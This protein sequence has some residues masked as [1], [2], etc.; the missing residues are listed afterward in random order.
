MKTARSDTLRLDSAFL[1]QDIYSLVVFMVER[2][3]SHL[4]PYVIGAGNALVPLH[5]N[6]PEYIGNA[7]ILDCTR[8][9]TLSV[10]RLVPHT[11]NQPPSFV[12][13]NSNEPFKPVHL[14]HNMLEIIGGRIVPAYQTYVDLF[15]NKEKE[16][17]VKAR[18]GS[19]GLVILCKLWIDKE[20]AETKAERARLREKAGT[21]PW[22]TMG[23]EEGEEELSFYFMISDMEPVKMNLMVPENCS[24]F[25]ISPDGRYIICLSSSAQIHVFDIFDRPSTVKDNN[26]TITY[27]QVSMETSVA[28]VKLSTPVDVSDAALMKQV[29]SVPPFVAYE[30]APDM[31]QKV[32]YEVHH[33]AAGKKMLQT[34]T[35]GEEGIEVK[36]FSSKLKSG[37]SFQQNIKD[38]EASL[39]TR[40][41]SHSFI[42]VHTLLTREFKL[43]VDDMLLL[44]AYLNYNSQPTEISR[45]HA[46]TFVDRLLGGR[47]NV[48][49]PR[50]AFFIDREG[51][52]SFSDELRSSSTVSRDGGSDDGHRPDDDAFT[53]A[54]ASFRIGVPPPT[55]VWQ[56]P[57]PVAGAPASDVSEPP[58]PLEQAL[59][60]PSVRA[61]LGAPLLPQPP[62]APVQPPPTPATGSELTDSPESAKKRRRAWSPPQASPEGG[63][64]NELS[65]IFE[66]RRESPSK[67]EDPLLKRQAE[68]GSPSS[69]EFGPLRPV[70]SDVRKSIGLLPEVATSPLPIAAGAA[71]APVPPPI[72]AGAAPAPVPP[73]IAG[74]APPP[75]APPPIAGGAPPPSKK[76]LPLK[77]QPS[78]PSGPPAAAS[79]TAS[80]RAAKDDLLEEL[81]KRTKEIAE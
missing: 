47:V 62:T 77:K 31:H 35:P 51:R 32:Y 70:G 66:S 34:G 13:D 11:G 57:M 18:K 55:P 37:R 43:L 3:R 46:D 75:P 33:T 27:S 79:P 64:V 49:T 44:S 81:R 29:K 22:T 45:P 6:G 53:A 74:G 26:G 69:P 20:T 1:R 59:A 7:I 21:P 71:P 9:E 68:K 76:N 63:I 30:N 41:L 38:I 8:G 28:S 12:I 25:N 24:T 17:R 36:D 65:R 67:F 10:L 60:Q 23:E 2:E 73:P 72:A 4:V 50:P 15:I 40:P 48:H 39:P 80:Q 16:A 61:A 42:D 78:P 19:L 54:L 14:Q 58:Q 5:N 56:L 52:F